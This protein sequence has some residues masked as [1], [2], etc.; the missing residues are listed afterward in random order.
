MLTSNA[1]E[2]NELGQHE[3]HI[4][5]METRLGR[6]C[7]WR[8]RVKHV[9]TRMHQATLKVFSQ[10]FCHCPRFDRGI[11][12]MRG[13]EAFV[14]RQQIA[15]EEL[16]SSLSEQFAYGQALERRLQL[17]SD[18]RIH[19][20]APLA[21]RS[22]YE[23]QYARPSHDDYPVHHPKRRRASPTYSS[24]YPYGTYQSKGNYASSV[25]E[26]PSAFHPGEY[27]NPTFYQDLHQDFPYNGQRPLSEDNPSARNP[28]YGTSASSHQPYAPSYTR[29]HPKSPHHEVTISGESMASKLEP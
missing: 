27:Y 2:K 4:R 5:G 12:D 29:P 6:Y 20:T 7:Y 3:H 13:G 25:Y 9:L 22:Y 19:P 11:T 26:Y 18:E 24:Q 16:K 17:L 14:L 15:I 28:L 21:P 10:N 8:R 1:S 23:E